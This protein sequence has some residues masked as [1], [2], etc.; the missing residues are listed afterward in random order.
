LP[1]TSLRVEPGTGSQR[2]Q[3]GVDFLEVAAT[4]EYPG[5]FVLLRVYEGGYMA[6]F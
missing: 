2:I 1:I 6:N 5:G 3:I 4:K